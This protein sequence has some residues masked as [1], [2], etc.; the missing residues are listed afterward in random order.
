L[1]T[2]C[3]DQLTKSMT[4]LDKVK[5]VSPNEDLNTVLQIMTQSDINQVPAGWDN[6]VVGIV[7]RDNIINFINTRAELGNR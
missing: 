2:L 7:V 1:K 5:S 4:P 6:K 3:T